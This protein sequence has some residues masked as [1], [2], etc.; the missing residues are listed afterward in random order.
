[1]AMNINIYCDES[2]HLENDHRRYMAL[3]AVYC[4]IDALG[5]INQQLRTLKRKHSLPENIEIKWTKVSPSRVDF[6]LDVIDY[7]FAEKLLR[8]RSVVIDKE[9]LSHDQH[10]QTHDDFYYK[11]YFLLLSRVLQPNNTYNI[12]LDIKDTLSATKVEKLHDVLSKSMLDFD[13][14]I[15]NRIQNV[16]SHEINT[17]QLAD[18]LIGAIQFANRDDVTSEA[19]KAVVERIREHSRYSLLKSTLPSEKK[20]NIFHWRGR[21]DLEHES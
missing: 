14:N 3:G 5:D 18:L 4:P 21:Q 15:I 6:F 11:M 8:F 20:L 1:M 16:R 12:Y 7:F 2:N 13:R 17:L 10:A 9:Q 19:K